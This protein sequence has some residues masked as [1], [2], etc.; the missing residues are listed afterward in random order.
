MEKGDKVYRTPY[1]QRMDE[2]I[3]SLGLMGF[4]YFLMLAIIVISAIF[5]RAHN[6]RGW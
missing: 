3:N 5:A 6:W 2:A 1:L 4:F